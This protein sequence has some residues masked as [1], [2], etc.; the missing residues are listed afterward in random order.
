[1]DATGMRVMLAP[2]RYCSCTNHTQ[3]Y[4]SLQCKHR[5]LLMLA[6]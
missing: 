3:Q 1:M 4:E 6:S 2:F 5:L